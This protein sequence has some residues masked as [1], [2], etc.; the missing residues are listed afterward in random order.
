V[1]P[2]GMSE[3]FRA[4]RALVVRRSTST[5]AAV[6]RPFNVVPKEYGEPGSENYR[7]VFEHKSKDGKEVRQVSFYE[8]TEGEIVR[9]HHQ[10]HTW[11]VLYEVCE[12]F[13]ARGRYHFLNWQTGQVSSEPLLRTRSWYMLPRLKNVKT[14]WA[15]KD[16]QVDGDLR[17]L[18]DAIANS[19]YFR[20]RPRTRLGTAMVRGVE[21]GNAYVT[22]ATAERQRRH[23]P[24]GKH[25][26]RTKMQNVYVFPDAAK[27]VRRRA[28][29]VA[30]TYPSNLPFSPLPSTVD[31]ALTFYGILKGRGWDAR[32][33]VILTDAPERDS[34]REIKEGGARVGG[35]TIDQVAKWMCRL[36]SGLQEG[37]TARK[38]YAKVCNSLV[39]YLAGHGE[40]YAEKPPGREPTREDD[41]M[42]EGFATSSVRE[43]AG[44]DGT[45]FDTGV[46]LDDTVN[47]TVVQKVYG[48][49]RTQLVIVADT[50]K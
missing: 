44:R 34:I 15:L 41:C 29:L 1:F 45:C 10:P 7:T 33:I 40:Q 21:G 27:R 13:P 49:P 48:L 31:D 14:C 17:N 8:D 18:E 43:V 5:T 46:V 11:I 38:K 37:T 3:Y 24:R 35:S 42:D 16:S 22:Y 9:H 20:E 36:V 32:D 26:C 25:V 30:C 6:E 19:R 50:C 4:L 28:V 47:E 39:L 23:G 2:T 12:A